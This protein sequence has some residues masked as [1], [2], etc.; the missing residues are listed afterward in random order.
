MNAVIPRHILLA[1]LCSTLILLTP[2]I[3][4]AEIAEWH[5][6][7]TID[8]SQPF[9]PSITAPHVSASSLRKAP[10]LTPVLGASVFLVRDWPV[11]PMIDPE[12]Y[13]EFGVTAQPGYEIYCQEIEFSLYNNFH[14]TSSWEIRSSED[15]YVAA[16]DSGSVTDI[17]VDGE[18]VLAHV[19]DIGFRSGSV[20]FRL[21]T[22][23]NTGTTDPDRR[24]LRGGTY[25]GRNLKIRG[26][27]YPELP[28]MAIAIW[29][30]NGDPVDSSDPL[31]FW[32]VHE[33]ASAGYLYKSVALT[34]KSFVNAF[35]AS[36]WP[37]GPAADL[38]KY[39]EFS[40]KPG[41][42]YQILY[43]AIEF[44]LYN[45]YEGT[46]S[47]Q[48][49]SNADAYASV[50]DSG[51]ETVIYGA[52]APVRADISQLQAM[53]QAVDFRL[54]TFNN[55]GESYADQRGLR[56]SAFG[57]EDLVIYGR[58]FPEGPVDAVLQPAVGYTLK[59][60]VPN[61]FRPETV[62][63]FRIPTRERIELNVYDLRGRRVRSL[64]AGV[65]AAGTHRATWNGR[66]GNGNRVAP[67][68]YW[69]QLKG[70]SFVR[71]S[72]MVMLE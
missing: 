26:V 52:G 39:F 62:I 13:L 55:S 28:M 25:G 46:S 61:P 17:I 14:G 35:M 18:P 32:G 2:S 11:S 48:I 68:V 15:G 50:L 24:G 36:G 47:W 37:T 45:N 54:Y 9:P 63:E 20:T 69:Y 5:L 10:T 1:G 66:D 21:Y 53:E 27:V 59:Q 43:D 3:S 60:N 71:T 30:P 6:S 8:S 44:S 12:K 40:L 42:G 67:G 31:Q 7:G 19:S 56:G 64:A 29:K 51:H 72:R 33:N 38:D 49:R 65:K 57:G 4:G 70:A 41:T 58:V 34:A 22:Y 16:L 23:D